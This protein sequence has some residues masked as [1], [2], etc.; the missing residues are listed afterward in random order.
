[1]ALPPL[2]I[3]LPRS[4]FKNGTVS[5]VSFSMKKKSAKAVEL[6]YGLKVLRASGLIV[7]VQGS[8]NE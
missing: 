8:A 1:M 2:V 7:V 3:D 5:M 4:H 6:Q